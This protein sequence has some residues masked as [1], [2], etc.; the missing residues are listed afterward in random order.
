MVYNHD[1]S[2]PLSKFKDKSKVSRLGKAVT[3]SGLGPSSWLSQMLKDSSC[4]RFV[5]E[6][7]ICPLK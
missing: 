6:D 2:V 1:G 4:V 3:S 7:G 5:G